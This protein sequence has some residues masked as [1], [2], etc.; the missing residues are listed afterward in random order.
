MAI[1]NPALIKFF[2]TAKH[3]SFSSGEIVLRGED[4]S[5]VV[6][7]RKGF[8]AVYSISDEGNR[9][10]HVL[11][12][13]GELFPLIWALQDIR[14]K[15]FYEAASDVV[16]AESP[17]ED[18]LAFIKKD[19]RASYDVLAQLAKQF[20]I[21]A[22][23]LDNLQYKSAHER[24]AYRLVFLASRFGERHGKSVIIKAPLTHELI[25]ESIN[26]A[27]ETV[28]REIEGLEKKNLIGRRQNYIVIKNIDQ[29]A[30]EFSQPVT[31]DLWG[32]MP[33]ADA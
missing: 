5:G 21:F 22:D 32:L 7:I 12:K 28:S 2:D 30:R 13:E 16:V 3:R 18:F 4:P 17:R 25:S 27:R 14:R 19:A 15:V 20:Y 29:M 1:S 9:Y 10:V 11:Y 31:L 24:V 8:V 33:A 26:L 23:S 6:C